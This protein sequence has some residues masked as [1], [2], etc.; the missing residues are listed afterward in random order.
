MIIYD[1]IL[2][3][4]FPNIGQL[5]NA[6]MILISFLIKLKSLETT[7]PGILKRV[8][9]LVSASDGCLEEEKPL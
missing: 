9:L 7:K 8:G 2:H 6:L 4:V 3:L 1:A 5:V